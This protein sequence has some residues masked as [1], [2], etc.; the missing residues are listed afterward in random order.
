MR[1]IV[2]IEDVEDNREL[3]YYLLRDEFHV[4]RFGSGEEALRHFAVETPD[5]IILD[6]RLPGM[7]GIEVLNRVRQHEHL[8]QLPVL[9]LTAHAMSGDRE[10]YLCAGFDEYA[11]KPIVDLADFVGIVRRLVNGIE[12]S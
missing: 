12:H 3:L 6:I 4:T 1:K 9:A 11:S 7:D 2:I 8:R 10:K 5:L